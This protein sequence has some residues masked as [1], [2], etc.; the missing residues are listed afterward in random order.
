[1]TTV[2]GSAVLL[3]AVPIGEWRLQ[4]G[5]RYHELNCLAGW[6]FPA[7]LPSP[8]ARSFE[9]ADTGRSSSSTRN[10]LHFLRF[11]RRNHQGSSLGQKLI[12]DADPGTDDALAVLA[13]LAD[14]A[15]DLVAVTASAGV[16]SGLQATRKACG[17]HVHKTLVQLDV[18]SSPV[19]TFDDVDTLCSFVGHSD[20]GAFI[21]GPLQFAV[22]GYRRHLALEGIPLHAIAALNV[23]AGAEVFQTDAGTVDVE[24]SGE[25]TRGITVVDRRRVG[26]GKA[27]FDIVSSI[28]DVG[29]I[30]YFTRVIRRICC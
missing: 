5:S 22:R 29:V 17:L 19:Q 8:L 2:T 7:D 25:L 15:I 1:M 28:N 20:S 24:T 6:T 26:S 27:N 30:D 13:A 9:K 4:A 18:N 3:S 23:A 21:A 10:P 14:P 11:H 16:V 12:I